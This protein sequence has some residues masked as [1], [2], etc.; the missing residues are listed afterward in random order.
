[1]PGQL[2]VISAPSGA[3]KSTILK[4]LKERIEGIGYSVSHTTRR[5]RGTEKDGTD[6]YF[7]E[8]EAFSRMIDAGDFVE[9]AQVYDD[10]YGTSFSSLNEQTAT[11]LDVLLDVDSQ[12][13]RNIKKN[14]KTSVLIYVLPPSLEALRKRL[15]A[16]GTDDESVIR[17][18]MEKVPHEIKQ[19]LWYDYII[20]NDDLEKAIE[21][22][23][24]II[25]STRCRT[26]Q[27]APVVEKLFDI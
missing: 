8:R 16:R 13:A 22:A 2:F 25:L 20:I 10:L 21:E 6:Y 14:Y 27:Q 12:G 11:G 5:P 3:G 24:A 1:M 17:A 4:A 23:R 9:W 15:V 7:V 18:R 19:C 26:A